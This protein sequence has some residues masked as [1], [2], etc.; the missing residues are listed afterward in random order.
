MFYRCDKLTSINLSNFDAS[1]VQNMK[2]M[3]TRYTNLGNIEISNFD[4]SKVTS[5]MCI[6]ITEYLILFLKVG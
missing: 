2:F 3:F 5:M 4:T 6:L 1:N